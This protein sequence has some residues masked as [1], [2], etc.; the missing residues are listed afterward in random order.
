MEK[1]KWI[2]PQLMVLTRGKQEEAV[3]VACKNG[4]FTPSGPDYDHERCYSN[5]EPACVPLCNALGAS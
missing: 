4:G 2:Q 3:L 5:D 1:R